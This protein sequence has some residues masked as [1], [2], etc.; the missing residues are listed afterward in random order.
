MDEE[1][2]TYREFADRLKISIPTVKVWVKQD[3]VKVRR[4]TARTVRIPRSELERLSKRP[5][6]IDVSGGL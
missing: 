4:F 3:R 5:V 2:L 1:Y 6:V